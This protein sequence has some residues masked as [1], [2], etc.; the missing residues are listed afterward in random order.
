MGK[1]KLGNW[2]VGWGGAIT[3][4]MPPRRRPRF[5]QPAGAPLRMGPLV[6]PK[7]QMRSGRSF[8]KTLTKKNTKSMRGGG[9]GKFSRTGYV[10][11]HRIPR[12]L[13]GPIKAVPTRSI[14]GNG[15]ACFASTQG[16]Q[17]VVLLGALWNNPLL[18]AIRAA[19][20]ANDKDSRYF[21]KHGSATYHLQNQNNFLVKATIYDVVAL[22]DAPSTSLDDP[23]EL[24]AKGILDEAGTGDKHLYVGVHPAMSPEFNTFYRI[25]RRSNITFVPGQ[26]HHHRVFVRHNRFVRASEYEYITGASMRKLTYWSFMVFHG[27]LGNEDD[28]G[29][30]DKCTYMA[31]RV[32]MAYHQNHVYSLLENNSPLRTVTQ[33]LPAVT[34]IVHMADIGLVERAPI[35]AE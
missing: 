26:L 29:G 14:F 11:S 8:T 22:R 1:R 23:V 30:T 3:P 19:N 5:T 7:M 9:A 18:L 34:N 33:S 13:V 35:S 20:D 10:K 24:F 12:S 21:L 25:V 17:A 16:R 6:R 2:N 32:D 15:A 4:Y 31:S 28:A 27:A